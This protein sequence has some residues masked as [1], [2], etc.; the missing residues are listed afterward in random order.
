LSAAS[1]ARARARELFIESQGAADYEDIKTEL[2]LEGLGTHS[3][4]VIRQWR[5]RDIKAGHVEPEKV[6]EKFEKISKSVVRV[7]DKLHLSER[8]EAA[9]LASLEDTHERM[10]RVANAAADKLAATIANMHIDTPAEAVLI[11]GIASSVGDSAIRLRQA[12]MQV[13]E[14]NMKTIAT[15]DGKAI[16]GEILPP[17]KPPVAGIAGA[18]EAFRKAS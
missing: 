18:L 16:E 7:A 3:I 10:L 5:S 17:S 11:A 14:N 12:L 4:A 1:I 13:R 8:L 2:E 9:T 6:P 15:G